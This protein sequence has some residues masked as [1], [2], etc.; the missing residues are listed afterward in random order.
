MKNILILFPFT[1][2]HKQQAAEAAPGAQ[3]LYRRY[4]QV[5]REEVAAADIVLGSPS[6]EWLKAAPRLEWVQLG[7]AGTDGYAVPGVLREN[8]ILTNATGIYGEVMAEYMLAGLLSLQK[9]LPLYQ[10]NRLEHR[11]H[12]EGRVRLITGSSA[13]VVGFGNIGSEF[14]RR[15][16]ALGCKVTGIRRNKTGKPDYLEALAQMDAL[17]SLL[18]EA[19]IVALS[20]PN[21]GET[22]RLFGRDRMEKMKPGAILINV[23]RGSA[24]DS[25]ALCEAL[26]SGRLG[27]AVL[28]VTDPEPLPREH[29]LW[30]A[31]NLILTP[32]VSGSNDLPEVQDGLC[33][34]A[35]ENLKAYF[36]GKPL[37]NVVDLSTGYRK[38][39]E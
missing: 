24:V 2:A 6:P 9:K 38:L 39:T 13:L 10:Q 5:T 19:D 31:P 20:L 8:T 17:D 28:D 3:I 33:R 7:S 32:H 36:E 26:N 22:R 18:P 16:S 12:P 37:K 14:A 15:L 34:L 30:D 11:W 25:A 27:G 4:S 1:E 21:T 23:G 29:P 35:L